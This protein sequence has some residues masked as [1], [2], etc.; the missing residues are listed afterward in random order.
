MNT[1][2]VRGITKVAALAIVAILV[3]VVA[4]ALFFSG[5]IP[6]APVEEEAIPEKIVIG[7]TLGLSGK[8]STE[9]SM[10]LWGVLT[11]V[12]WVNEVNGG[13]ELSGKKV[14]IEFKYY[15]DE[16]KK[17]NVPSLYE[18][19]ITVDKVDFLLAPYA[20]SLT[21]AAASVADKYGVIMLSHGGASNIIFEQGYEYVVQVLTP[22][23]KYLTG[24]LDMVKELDPDARK[25]AIIYKDSEFPRMVAEGAKDHAERLGFDVVFYS[26]YPADATDLTPLLTDMATTNPDIV[27]ASSHFA[28]GQLIA[29][30]MAELNI[31]AKAIGITVAPAL[32]KFYEALGSLAEGILYPG[33]WEVGVKY[34]PSAAE[35]LGIEWWGPTQDEFL[36][37]FKQVTMELT[38]EEKIPSYHAA[39]AAA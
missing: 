30:Q 14:P 32:P 20:S 34:S 7:G 10:S 19:L 36:D 15:D 29:S 28:D 31:N 33:Q 2:S 38:G 3:I 12:K 37:L 8:Y 21:F 4:G 6:L 16:S 1:H 26:S 13:I 18:R 5:I 25:V 27:L 11:A 39:E 9:G 24:I 35:A 23:T 22:A 17:E